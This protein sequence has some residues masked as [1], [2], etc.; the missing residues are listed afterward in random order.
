VEHEHDPTTKSIVDAVLKPWF[1]RAHDLSATTGRA[2]SEDTKAINLL[3]K[4][5]RFVG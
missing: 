3:N 2:G 4:H 5:S 1:D